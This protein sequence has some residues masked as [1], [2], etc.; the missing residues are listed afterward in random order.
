VFFLY[1]PFGGDRLAKLVAELEPIART[2]ALTICC[3][4]LRL[5]PQPWLMLERP[6]SAGLAIYR[7]MLHETTFGRRTG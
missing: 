4:D 5:P 2:R 3:V 6:R 7:S 1:C